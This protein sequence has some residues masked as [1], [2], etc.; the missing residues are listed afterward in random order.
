MEHNSPQKRTGGH[1][2]EHLFEGASEMRVEVVENQVNLPRGGVCVLKQPLYEM[3]EIHLGS[4]FGNLD[5]PMSA[6][7]LHRHE[8]IAGTF[9]NVFVIELGWGASFHGQYR[10]VVSNQLLTFLVNANHR[11]LFP[12]GSRIQV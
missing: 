3:N 1:W 7:G 2:A 4:T 11:L 5:D 10:S 9:S 12:V 6:S 8:Y